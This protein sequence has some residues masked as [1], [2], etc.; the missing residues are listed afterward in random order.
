MNTTHQRALTISSK[1]HLPTDVIRDTRSELFTCLLQSRYLIRKAII[2]NAK[3]DA[4]IDYRA[5]KSVI[6]YGDISLKTKQTYA[7]N[8]NTK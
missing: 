7:V 6:I 4:K 8:N 3:L 2:N 5:T 1:R